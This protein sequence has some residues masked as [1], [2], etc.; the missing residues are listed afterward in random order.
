MST[1]YEPGTELNRRLVV[2]PLYCLLT[3]ALFIVSQPSVSTSA[4][5]TTDTKLTQRF[6]RQCAIEAK[7]LL[8][9][10]GLWKYVS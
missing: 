6:Y 9:A 10:Q 7:D 2:V 3:F 8:R 1:G 4:M 5:S